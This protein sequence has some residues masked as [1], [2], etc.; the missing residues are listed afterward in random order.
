MLKILRKHS[1]HWLIAAI[2]GAIVVVFGLVVGW[3]LGGVDRPTALRVGVI[4]ARRI[5]SF[6]AGVFAGLRDG[7][8]P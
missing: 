7:A 8:L 5:R 6:A 3:Y 2:I 4:A 1:Q